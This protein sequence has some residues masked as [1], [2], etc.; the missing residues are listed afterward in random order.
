MSGLTQ[1]A[2]APAAR[3]NAHRAGRAPSFATLREARDRYGLLGCYAHSNPNPNGRA[4]ARIFA[5]SIGVPEDVAN[6]NST[7]CLAAYLADQGVTGIAVDMG[8][9]LGHPSTIIAS[10]Q[11][12]SSGTQIR[13]GGAAK[14]ARGVRLPQLA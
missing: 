13:L 10:A 5:P 11:R 8:D 4:A 1:P 7:A 12:S 9:H 14:I 3:A 2:T 6:A